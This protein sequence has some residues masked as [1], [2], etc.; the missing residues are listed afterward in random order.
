MIYIWLNILPITAATLL[1]LGI[2]ALWLRASNRTA[3]PATILAATLAI[4][5]LAA[6]LAGAV[7]L[8]PPQADPWTMAL[9]SAFIIWIGFVAPV[10]I[11]TLSV[12]GV[13]K[14]ATISA[15]AYWLITML[16]Q[17]ALLKG[18]GLV[19]PPT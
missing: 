12:H 16:A 8:A 5:W 15:A 6:I 3:K 7:I 13:G 4:F 14:A 10:L 9:G 18:M 11:V 19:A 17:A 2:G 1:G